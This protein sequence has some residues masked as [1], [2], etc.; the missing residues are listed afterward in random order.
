LFTPSLSFTVTKKN[1]NVTTYSFYTL[2]TTRMLMG[3]NGSYEFYTS[4]TSIDKIKENVSKLMRG[5][6]IQKDY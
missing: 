6:T 5:E 1:G 3:V 4:A 2:S